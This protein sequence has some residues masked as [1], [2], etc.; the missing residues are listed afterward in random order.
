MFVNPKQAKVLSSSGAFASKKINGATIGGQKIDPKTVLG[1]GGN[2]SS[3]LPIEKD[4]FIGGLVSGFRNAVANPILATTGRDKL[5]TVD[6][7]KG[8]IDTPQNQLSSILSNY[9]GTTGMVVGGIME[10]EPLRKMTSEFIRT[11]KVDSATSKEYL[12]GFQNNLLAGVSESAAP[13]L[14][15]VQKDI[16]ITGIN[17]K[18]LLSSALGVDGAPRIEDV[19]KQ[20]PTINMIVKGKEYFAN[21]DFTS[22]NGIFKVLDNL[23]SNT[24]LSSLLDLKTEFAIMN[25]LTK[26]LMAFDA[27]DLFSRVGDWFRNDDGA[28]G[29]ATGY[30][31]ETEYYLDNLQNAIDE[32]SLTFLEG[33]LTRVGADK[34]LD[35]NRNYV[36]DFLANFTIRYDKEPSAELGHRLNNLMTQIDKNWAKSQLIAGQGEYYTDLKPFKLMSNDAC[37]VFMLAEL[38]VT[39]LTIAEYYPIRPMREYMKSLYPLANI[40]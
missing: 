12:K 11:G 16:G 19:L 4:S 21:A 8:V 20:N 15:K 10:N 30:N 26:G 24:P 27:P 25:V 38:Y 1:A 6:P 28:S 9:F 17:G 23:T 7:Y 29:N 31:N 33:L 14:D 13:W 32:S 3:L 22:A 37:R 2:I 39:E 34:I 40:G 36:S 18:Q 5:A 35:R